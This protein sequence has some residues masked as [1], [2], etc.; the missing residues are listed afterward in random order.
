MGVSKL[1]NL[2]SPA[3]RKIYLESL[4]GKKLAI[5]IFQ[6]IKKIFL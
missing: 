3:G 6:C 5:G 4:Q 1:W 2:L